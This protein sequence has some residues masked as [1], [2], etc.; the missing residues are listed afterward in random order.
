MKTNLPTRR[1]IL[2][3]RGFTLIELLVVIAIIAILAG[4]LLPALAK[5]KQKGQGAQ[6]MS[7]NKQ[8][9]TAWVMYQHDNRDELCYSSTIFETG[10]ITNGVWCNGAMTGNF[11]ERQNWDPDM[12]LIH[13]ALWKYAPSYG[14]FKCPADRKGGVVNGVFR[15]RVRSMSMN[16][17]LHFYDVDGGIHDPK[18]SVFTRASQLTD[19]TSLFVFIDMRE[20]SVNWGNFAQSMKGFFGRPQAYEWDTDWPG[21]Y[22]NRAGGLSFADGHAE[23]RRW[24]DGRTF[25]AVLPPSRVETQPGNPDIAWMQQRSTRPK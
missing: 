14:I 4:M 23:I 17:Y 12:H 18:F 15:K 19:P 6:C 1:A 9:V 10:P 3:L 20:D 16:Y 21:S 13:G 5:A 11:N 22:H 2:K 8:L 24:L 7:N 25:P